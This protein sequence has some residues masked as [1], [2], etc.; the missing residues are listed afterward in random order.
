M[1]TEELII[2]A[3]WH[4]RGFSAGAKQAQRD[5]D[6]VSRNA[7]AFNATL[8]ALGATA[9]QVKDASDSAAFSLGLVVEQLRHLEPAAES[10]LDGLRQMVFGIPNL[11]V[12]QAAGLSAAAAAL[13]GSRGPSSGLSGLWW[14]PPL[15]NASRKT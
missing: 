8:G 15:G 1:A 2:H 13:G 12:A 5:L 4:D 9:S 6:T 14:V 11:D 7:R 3:R 10:A